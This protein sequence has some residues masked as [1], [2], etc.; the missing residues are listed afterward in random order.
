VPPHLIIPSPLCL[1]FPEKLPNNPEVPIHCIN[2]VLEQQRERGAKEGGSVARGA[3]ICSVTKEPGRFE[4]SQDHH[5]KT[6]SK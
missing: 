5:T 1:H 4:S 2:V 3:Y 6:G